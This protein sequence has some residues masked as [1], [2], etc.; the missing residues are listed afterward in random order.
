MVGMTL[1]PRPADFTTAGEDFE[2]ISTLRGRRGINV[3]SDG[4]LANTQNRRHA[5]TPDESDLGGDYVC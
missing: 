1:G 4:D 5:V 3:N 2:M